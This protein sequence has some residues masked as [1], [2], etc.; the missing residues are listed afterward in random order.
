M[1]IKL[2]AS[3][4]NAFSRNSFSATGLQKESVKE[5]ILSKVLLLPCQNHVLTLRV[6]FK[7]NRWITVLTMRKTSWITRCPRTYLSWWRPEPMQNCL[8]RWARSV[9][10]NMVGA[11]NRC[12]NEG[13]RAAQQTGPRDSSV[14]GEGHQRCPSGCAFECCCLMACGSS[15]E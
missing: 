4:W 11:I 6:Y 13:T 5:R 2:Q 9:G 3:L 7:S 8:V 14:H 1:F 10:E 15:W 12:E